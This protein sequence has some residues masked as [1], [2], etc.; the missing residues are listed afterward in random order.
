VPRSTYYYQ[1]RPE[2]AENLR[3]LRRRDQLYLKRPFFGSRKM[4]VELEVNRKR[5]QRL[6]RILGRIIIT[7]KQ[8]R[9]HF[10]TRR[11]TAQ[12]R[13]GIVGLDAPLDLVCQVNSYPYKVWGAFPDRPY[14]GGETKRSAKIAGAN[15]PPFPYL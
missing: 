2:C 14:R 13:F 12:V 7:W 3:L 8:I 9:E 6:M 15:P 10:V 11:R 1:P 4:A 5:I